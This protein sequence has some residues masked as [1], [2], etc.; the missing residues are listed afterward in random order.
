MKIHE[1]AMFL[2]LLNCFN[3]ISQ[4][5]FDVLRYDISLDLSDISSESFSGR[6]AVQLKSLSNGMQQVE[7]SLLKL[8]VDSV[9]LGLTSLNFS[10]DDTTIA[11]TLPA[12]LNQNDSA[13]VEIYYHGQPATDASWGGFYFSNGYAFNIGVAFSSN[14]HAFGRVWF[15]CVDS[16]TDKAVYEM[17]VTTASSGKAFCSGLL[18]GSTNNPDGT[19]TWHWTMSQEIPTYLASVAVAGYASLEGKFASVSGDS[20]PYIL[21]ALPADT[22][23]LKSSFIHLPDAF[24]GFES[25]FG[26]HRFD[27]VGF[28]VVPFNG[29]AMEHATNIA[30]PRF[31]VTGGLQY[32]TLMAHEFSHH[33]WGDLVTCE[34]A[35]DMWLNE[36]WASYSEGIFLERVYGR[37]AYKEEIRKN[38]KNVLQYAHIRD[39]G[40]RAV[41]GVPHEYTY[42][43]TVYDKG[44]DV[45]HTLRGY[46]GDSLF[47]LCLKDY[48]DA[49][50]FGN[51]SS[52]DF[53]DFLSQRSGID[54]TSFFDNWVFNPGFPHF[55]V[56]S[57]FTM[58]NGSDFD[59]TVF[60][61]Q[62][63]KEAPSLYSNIPLDLTFFSENFDSITRTVVFSGGCGIYH[64][65]LGF[66][67]AFVAIDID[68]K[69]SDAIT[70]NYDII[71]GTGTY[72]FDEAMMTLTVTQ[73]PSNA[74][75][76]VEHNWVA[77]DP[78]K[79]T[80]SGLHISSERYWKVDGIIPDG[81]TASARITYDGTAANG[82]LDRELITNSEDSLVVLFRPDA[83]SEWSIHPGFTINTQGS[84]NNKTGQITINNIRKGEY[85]LG[86]NDHDRAVTDTQ[87]VNTPCAV[88]NAGNLPLDKSDFIFNVFPNPA[89][90]SFLIKL[91]KPLPHDS[92]ITILDLSGKA[93]RQSVMPKGVDKFY[94]V[95]D[96]W[97]KTAYLIILEDAGG[98]MTKKVMVL[99]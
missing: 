58:Q 19:V 69:I 15:P 87:A 57:F 99:N 59:V 67:P 20:V 27:R 12:A 64:A 24:E 46:L 94:V 13:E 77:P 22:A 78:M 76:R 90:D 34:T 45:A 61:R 63:L 74:L 82:Y 17:R 4:P 72:A 80:I 53:R 97:S 93:V 88:L 89:N 11:F 39:D 41:S 49:F 31:A 68:E 16:F 10:H 65:T 55:S 42:G 95:T 91:E 54:L 47:F 6:C 75:V 73:A 33:W 23:K 86:I 9:R 8:Q 35:E 21:A 1:I 98:R 38:H 25:C 70:D 26:E 52:Y 71:S 30:Y 5:A 96:N 3:G 7:L 84:A 36:G 28:V 37:E 81:F 18:Q 92:K 48:L 56:D 79:D 40:Y 50:K 83:R 51:A 44:A 66:E 85:A 43:S 2:L 32:E 60:I 14:P 29:G 62:R